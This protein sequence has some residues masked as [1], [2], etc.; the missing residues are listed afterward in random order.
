[1]T[2]GQLLAM[3]KQ[4]SRE[5]LSLPVAFKCTENNLEGKVNVSSVTLAPADFGRLVLIS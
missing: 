3:L 2:A 1:M 4:L 5:E